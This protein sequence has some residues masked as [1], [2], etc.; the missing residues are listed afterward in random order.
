MKTFVT[1]FLASVS[2][3]AGQTI[4]TRSL[5]PD[6]LNDVVLNPLLTTT[7]LFPEPISGVFGLGLISGTQTTGTVQIEH[8]DSSNV[9]VLHPLTNDAHVIATI[10]IGGKLILLNLVSGGTPDAAVTFISRRDQEVHKSVAV[11]PQEIKDSR[12]VYGTDLLIGLL[13]RSRDSVLL[14]PLYPELYQGYKTKE[15]QFVSDSGTVK[16]TVTTV[17]RFSKE[18]AIVLQGVVENETDKPLTF[19]GL[20]ATVQVNNLVE[21]I[22]ILDCLRPIP[23]HTKTLIDVVIQGAP[24]GGREDLSIDNDFR[25]MLPGDTGI[26]S[27]KNGSSGQPFKVT[28]P[29]KHP[30]MAQARVKRDTQ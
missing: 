15:T 27:F 12:P 21:P 22:K 19:D 11:T 25:I 10:L 5:M 4:A 18:D 7:L 2:L 23:P 8:P 14:R 24:D 20:A 17:H 26:W 6:V 3:V 9:I 30:P 16:T 1:L 29:I 28:P 13:R